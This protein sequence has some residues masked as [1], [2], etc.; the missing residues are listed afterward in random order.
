[1]RAVS[2][3]TNG[4]AKEIVWS[5]L[6]YHHDKN[7]QSSLYSILGDNGV[8]C[9]S[10]NVEDCHRVW[11]DRPIIKLSSGRESSKALNKKKKLNGSSNYSSPPTV[12][13]GEN[14]KV[15]GKR[16]FLLHF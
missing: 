14:L 10:N 2:I 8:V 13:Y 5:L 9:K 3:A 1:M 16:S 7:F 4:T 12:D 6:V 11:G 15:F